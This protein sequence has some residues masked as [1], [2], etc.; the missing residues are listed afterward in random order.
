M[1]AKTYRYYDFIM[2]GF[3]TILLCANIIG[4]SKVVHIGPA[5]GGFTFGAGV[6]FFPISY[7]F[8]DL[9]TEV[10]GYARSRRVVWAGF[11]AMGFA[12]LMSWTILKLPAAPGWPHQQA[13][14][15]AFGSAPRILLASVLAYLCGEFTNSYTLAK[16]KVW[17][18]GK[19][20]WART[21]GS[22]LAGEA[23]D[24]VIFYPIAFLGTWSNELVLQVLV[25]NYFLKVLWEALATPLTYKIV[26]KLKKAESEDYYDRKTRFTPFSLQT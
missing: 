4:A 3:V 24:S 8:G 19:H 14:E 1:A 9:L 21:I 10:Y 22:T 18:Q 16:M 20:L 6:L 17:T 11:A 23:V 25:S 13:Y 2:A 12:S 7:L 15:I 5:D 26:A